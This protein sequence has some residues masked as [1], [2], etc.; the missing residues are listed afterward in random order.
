MV[1]VFNPSTQEGSRGRWISELRRAWSS[2][3]GQPELH[4]NKDPVSRRRKETTFLEDCPSFNIFLHLSINSLTHS[5]TH[6][7]IHSFMHAFM[8]ACMHLFSRV[9]LLP[10]TST[11]LLALGSVGGYKQFNT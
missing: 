8:Q 7:F 11:V 6:S 2:Y 1:P 5:V 3:I 4:C 10:V 9:N